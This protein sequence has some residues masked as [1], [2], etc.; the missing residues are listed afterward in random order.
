MRIISWA[1]DRFVGA[2]VART[3]EDGRFAFRPYVG[4]ELDI[5]ATAT[6]PRYLPLQRRIPWIEGT[7]TQQMVLRMYGKDFEPVDGTTPDGRLATTIAADYPTAEVVETQPDQPLSEPI[8]GTIIA[9]AALMALDHE[10]AEEVR[11]VIA[12]DPTTGRWRLIATDGRD[13]RVSPSGR[14]LS[15]SLSGVA[16]RLQ[17]LSLTPPGKPRVILEHCVG[18]AS[19]FP[20]SDRL[21]VNIRDPKPQRY[22]GQKYW[23]T[24]REKYCLS[25]QGKKLAAMDLPSPYVAFDVSRDGKRV[26]MHW[27]THAS[28]TGAQLYVADVDGRHL[29]TIAQ[30]RSQYYWYPRFSPD[31]NSVV[32]KHLDA[33][34]SGR[35][36]VRILLLDGSGERWISL[37]ERYIPEV[38]CWSPDGNCVAIAAY[39]A[40]AFSGGEKVS[41]I[42]IVDSAGHRMKEVKLLQA[43]GLRIGSIDW[44]PAALV[45]E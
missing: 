19:W 10:A 13:P 41:K 12:I 16:N 42:Y 21:A 11:G 24:G 27:D 37:G 38:A 43:D 35:I 23:P 8:S 9:G 22:E 45:L 3:A 30:K 5:L 1:N 14:L 20:S 28:A 26:A 2:V 40:E 31:G 7:A 33:S 15:Y 32:A 4:N 36:T 39:A 6:E 25:V 44:A 18:P 29:M 17:I 34:D